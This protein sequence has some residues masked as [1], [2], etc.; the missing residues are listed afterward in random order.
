MNLGGLWVKDLDWKH[1]G[2]GLMVNTRAVLRPHKEHLGWGPASCWS[3]LSSAQRTQTFLGTP[4]PLPPGC[5]PFTEEARP[6]CLCQQAEVID[7]SVSIALS[8]F[9]MAPELKAN[10]P[11]RALVRES[12]KKVLATIKGCTGASCPCFPP[13]HLVSC[14]LPLL[15]WQGFTKPWTIKIRGTCRDDLIVHFLHIS[16]VADLGLSTCY[17]RSK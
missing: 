1:M 6:L 13:G 4:V 16:S 9:S 17:T 10:S 12:M 8:T 3:V 15:G 14:S 2:K 5:H 11:Q 7:I